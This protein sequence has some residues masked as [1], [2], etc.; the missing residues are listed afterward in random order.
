[1]TKPARVCLILEGSYP[2]ITGG[3]SA[4]VQDL[5]SSLPELEFSLLTISPKAGQ[6]LRYAPPP[7]VME[8]RDVVLGSA[9]GA[10]GRR[11]GR[12]GVRGL[13]A[14]HAGLFSG[15]GADMLGLLRAFA[16][17]GSR[18]DNRLLSRPELWNLLVNMNR[19]RNPAYAFSDYFW[20]W[21][22]A[23][24]MMFDA[25][26]ADTP[27][28]DVYHAISTGFAGLAAL[29]AKAR[30]G[31]P[32]FL[33]EHGL[34]HKEREIEIRKAGFVRGYQRDMWI[35]L[36]NSLSRL[37]YGQA[38]AITALFEENRQK[39]IELGADPGRCSVVPNGID[40][41]RF[42]SVRREKREGFHVGLVGRIVPIKDV[43]T[44]IAA[45][46]I[47][48]ES[49]PDARFY[50]IGPTDEDPDYYEECR[51]LVASFG[52]GE[53]FVFTGRQDVLSYYSFLDLM[54]LTSVREA[55]PLVILEGW[56]AGVQTVGTKV[57][58]VPELLNYDERFLAPSK[59]PEALARCILFAR[60]N[61]ELMKRL[62]AENAERVRKLYDKED[63]IRRFGDIYSSLARGSPWRA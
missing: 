42:S 44:Y 20:A 47:V 63:M 32:F 25:L 52:L 6:E 17:E 14:M 33:S 29:N 60:A 11:P 62:S 36:Y 8:H 2:F 57:G 19:A 28:A 35:N 26:A 21:Q 39:Q 40:L 31:A 53:R 38:D 23:H 49:A 51:A 22:S 50:A 16:Q 3:V 48:V 24:R 58:N 56:A 7:N 37:C 59:D 12:R 10:A 54:A 1:M 45:A 5:I 18:P 46:R 4:W 27:K 43:K 15:K 61:P 30:T 34:Y 13:I 41:R 9:A 55:Q